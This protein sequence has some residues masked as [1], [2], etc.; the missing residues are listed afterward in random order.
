MNKLLF[1]LALLTLSLSAVAQPLLFNQQHNDAL[2]FGLSEDEIEDYNSRGYL[3]VFNEEKHNTKL[4]KQLFKKKVGKSH[5]QK[6][7]T[8]NTVY[9]V[10]A[11]SK[12]K[13]YRVDYIFLDGNQYDY[14][15]IQKIRKKVKKLLDDGV[16]FE[17]V[18]R[19]YSMDQNSARGGDSGWFKKET[20]MEDFYQAI[21]NS[22]YLANE[23]FEIDLPE[24]NWYYIVKKNYTPTALNEILILVEKQPLK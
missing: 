6:G 15:Q 4:A 16:K 11:E 20:T 13:H 2:D 1:L 3:E 19:Q 22:K 23:V 7:R 24:K 18:A 8:E 9:T 21:S 12:N 10:V 17:S 5:T 14:E